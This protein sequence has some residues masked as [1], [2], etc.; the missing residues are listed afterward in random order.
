VDNSSGLR[1]RCDALFL[2]E[3]SVCSDT[4]YR[5]SVL[6]FHPKR[7][8]ALENQKLLLHRYMEQKVHNVQSVV[9]FLVLCLP[10]Y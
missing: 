9:P 5:E 1:A 3:M 8:V 2:N 4:A 7:K 6:R 10:D